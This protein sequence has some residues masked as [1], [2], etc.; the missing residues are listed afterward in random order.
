MRCSLPAFID[1]V[2]EYTVKDG[3]MYIS[4]G[5]FSLAMPLNVFLDGCELGK[6]AIVDWQ[7]RQCRIDGNVTYIGQ[8]T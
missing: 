2:P 8:K 5:D 3:R 7:R 6:A 1:E 4:M